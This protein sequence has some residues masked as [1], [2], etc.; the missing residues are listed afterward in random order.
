M[1][2]TLSLVLG[3]CGLAAGAASAQVFTEKE[4]RSML[5]DEKGIGV[6][7]SQAS[8]LS[9]TD[10]ALLQE[11]A[12]TQNYYAAVA[13]P[14]EEGMFSNAASSAANFHKMEA[15]EAAALST[16]NSRKISGAGCQIVL[17]VYPK[18]WKAMPL[19]LSRD[20][21]EGF[22][23]E[24]R[25]ARAPKVMAISPSTGEWA[26]GSGGSAQT[27]AISACNGKAKRRG[28]TDCLIV[29]KDD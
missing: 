19:Q 14:P 17:R 24:Y 2:K 26:V 12:K 16:C 1:R 9:E 25:R 13:V 8:F 11:V 23:K 15:A 21:T 20:A 5:F 3:L 22:R 7:I 29:I 10:R 6:A 27:S 28:V 18:S 4:A